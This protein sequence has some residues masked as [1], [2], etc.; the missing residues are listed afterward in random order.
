MSKI[1]FLDTNVYLHYQPVDQIDWLGLLKADAVTIVVPQVTIR[2][3]NT[4]KDL[5]ASPRVSRRAGEVLKTLWGLFESESEAR[6]RE[7][8]TVRL[9]EREPNVDFGEYDLVREVRDD[10]LIAAVIMCQTETPDAETTLVTSD[11]GVGLLAK[12]RRL[13][14]SALR[15]PG[16]LR[17]PEETDPREERIRALEQELS[18]LKLKTPQLSLTFPDGSQ[19][20]RLVLPPPI[21]PTQK[22]LDNRL[23]DI[24]QR[25][26][27]LGQQPKPPADV[28]ELVRSIAETSTIRLSF[29][30]VSPEDIA[31]YNS[32]LEEYY[33]RYAQYLQSD[34]QFRNLQRRTIELT[35]LIANDGTAPAEDMDVSM[36]FPDG[37]ELL[38]DAD[39]PAP[40]SPPGPPSKPLTPMEKL[41]QQ[42]RMPHD[43]LLPPSWHA[44]ESTTHPLDVTPPNISPPSIRRTDSY[45]VE[46]DVAR[47]KHRTQET[48][49]SLHVVFDTFDSAQSFHI[50][51]SIL[52]ANVPQEITGQLHVIIEKE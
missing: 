50:D 19:C 8:V 23:A 41:V 3:L 20:A 7:R 11:A 6:I 52:A 49:L 9:Q 12:A 28:S 43:M 44:L 4:L 37:L 35:V 33:K 36:I 39:Y 46:L 40:P 29:D 34:L 1:V 16:I 26:P 14:I 13:G 25:H 22:E 5:R 24:K 21:Q 45:E 10:C 48:C 42:T 18:V 38:T 32:Q 47:I 2:E 15:L 51:Y 17:L 27:K 31:K 30:T